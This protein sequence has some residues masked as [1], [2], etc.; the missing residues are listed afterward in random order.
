M[1]KAIALEAINNALK[2]PF[3]M[4]PSQYTQAPAQ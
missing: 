2:K 4:T 3:E 1:E